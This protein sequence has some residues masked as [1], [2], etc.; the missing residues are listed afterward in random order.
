MSF[1]EVKQLKA[2][3]GDFQALFNIDFT[4]FSNSALTNNRIEIINDSN[5][6]ILIWIRGKLLL[7]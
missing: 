4:K 3:Y 1:L 5:D 2:F 7:L 6:K